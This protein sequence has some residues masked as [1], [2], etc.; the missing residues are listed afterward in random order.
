M[1]RSAQTS[2]SLGKEKKPRPAVCVETAT[3]RETERERRTHAH[4]PDR[5]K[6]Q[7]PS[8]R[9]F[10]PPCPSHT[11]QAQCFVPVLACAVMAAA[12][13]QSSSSWDTIPEGRQPGSL[14]RQE[15]QSFIQQDFEEEPTSGHLPG[16]LRPGRSQTA[17][18]GQQH[19]CRG[20]CTGPGQGRQPLG[21]YVA[22][23]SKPRGR[24]RQRPRQPQ[25]QDPLMQQRDRG[26]QA[27]LPRPDF[28]TPACCRRPRSTGRLQPSRGRQPS[29]WRCRQL[30]RKNLIN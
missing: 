15:P 9:V 22:S 12:T 17:R 28:C 29:S 14:P 16:E 20:R 6:P 3:E 5:E 11:C 1:M 30:P 21:S 2:R 19:W 18:G 24:S 26:G 7:L 25:R 8:Q 10:Q 4:T 13:R 27:S 23:Q